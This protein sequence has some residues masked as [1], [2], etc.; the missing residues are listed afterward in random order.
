MKKSLLLLLICN[1][2]ALS[3][4]AQNQSCGTMENWNK[5]KDKDP[6]ALL[7][8]EQLEI[9]TQ[10][11]IKENA[12]P[13]KTSSLITIPV[14]VHV[15]YNAND[16]NISDAQIQSQIDVLNDDFR[17]LNTDSLSDTHPFWPEAAD[18]LI[19]FCLALQDP[20]GNSTNGITRT[21]TNLTSFDNNGDEKF[22]SSGGKDNW[23]PT[24]YLNIWVCNLD[25]TGGTLGYAT[26]PS[27][28]TSIPEEDGVVIDYRAFGTLGTAGTGGFNVNDLGRTA[29]HE[30]G[31]WLNLRHIWGDAVCGDDFVSDTEP[32][33]EPNYGCPSFPYNDFNS[34]GSGANGEMYMNYMDYV[35]DACMVMFTFGQS[36]RMDATLS[37]ER[38]ALLTSMG[39]SPATG[40]AK[41]DI[42]PAVVNLF[43][44]PTT[45]NLTIEGAEGMVTVYDIYGRLVLVTNTNTLDISNAADGIYFVRVLDEQGKVYVGKVVKE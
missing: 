25:G 29:S 7:R 45:G 42:Q 44:N 8:M 17:L 26:F 27:D 30:V 43:P 23:D 31:H 20:N 15:I 16:E 4:H 19:E 22:T 5:M 13:Y 41:A 38:S 24:K 21:M 33:E 10:Q 6:N 36:D 39:C 2:M 35:D 1:V 14:V 11:W 3:I 28:L 32:A 34:C 9:K 37:T 40:I 18:C 12:G